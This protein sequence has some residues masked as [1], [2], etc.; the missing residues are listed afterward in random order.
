MMRVGLLCSQ[1]ELATLKGLQQEWAVREDG[2]RRQLS[3]R[4]QQLQLFESAPVASP[5]RPSRPS[6]S[7]DK[8]AF[9][10]EAEALAA[11]KVRE[12]VATE[13]A[14]W[15]NVEEAV[16]EVMGKHRAEGEAESRAERER[17]AALA[18]AAKLRRALRQAEGELQGL[19]QAENASHPSAAGGGRGGLGARRE[20]MGDATAK[21]RGGHG[22]GGVGG[23]PPGSP[24][25]GQRGCGVIGSSSLAHAANAAAVER[26]ESEKKLQRRLEES[27]SAVPQELL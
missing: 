7:T 6:L 2:L 20:G 12:A 14:R 19:R 16:G 5:P 26:W 23:S 27:Y 13:R 3:A 9:A 21:V 8:E 25:G 22:G 15:R 18:D 24:S 17:D 11:R 4:E 1:S 10:A